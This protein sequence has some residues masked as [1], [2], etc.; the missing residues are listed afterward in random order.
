[1]K[2]NGIFSGGGVRWQNGHY[3]SERRGSPPPPVNNYY[4]DC[5][6]KK[7]GDFIMTE[8]YLNIDKISGLPSGTLT[9]SITVNNQTLYQYLSAR[10]VLNNSWYTQNLDTHHPMYETTYFRYPSDLTYKGQFN[11]TQNGILPISTTG[12]PAN[13]G[14]Y[15]VPFFW[16]N[17]IC[18]PNTLN[19]IVT[20]TNNSDFD[21]VTGETWD[22]TGVLYP[23]YEQW[24]DPTEC[25]LTNSPL[26]T[27]LVETVKYLGVYDCD[28]R[29]IR[30]IWGSVFPQNNLY[31]SG[32]WNQEL[33]LPLRAVNNGSSYTTPPL[34]WNNWNSGD[35]GE[36]WNNTTMYVTSS[37]LFKSVGNY[38]PV[39]TPNSSQIN[40]FSI[41]F[42][43][44]INSPRSGL[45]DGRW[46]YKPI[47]KRYCECYDYNHQNIITPALYLLLEFVLIDENG[48]VIGEVVR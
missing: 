22:N 18:T 38:I 9:K 48:C 7:R 14:I 43:H 24:F 41:G 8:L 36:K 32:N 10:D 23:W 4:L 37:Q 39:Y 16:Y 34:F 19:D 25:P 15:Y 5:G 13:L 11:L 12:Y 47:V 3:Q 29:I 35:E 45:F 33:N 21:F 46:L 28:P 31:I 44:V 26:N 20:I 27:N 2:R 17:G 30:H 42:Y 6:W 1:M 40:W